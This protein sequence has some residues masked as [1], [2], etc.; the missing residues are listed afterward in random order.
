MRLV[1]DEMM[2]VTANVNVSVKVNEKVK[3]RAG[4]GDKAEDSVTSPVYPF[5][6]L[7]SGYLAHA[8]HR[9]YVCH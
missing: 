1:G 9:A 4:E 5:A 6:R 8:R 7:R 2:S 3:E